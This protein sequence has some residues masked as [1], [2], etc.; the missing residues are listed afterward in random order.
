MPSP[1]SNTPSQ[2]AS[3][4]WSIVLTARQGC[5]DPT[6]RDAM[7]ELAR[8]YW[9]P[10]YAFVRR[11]GHNATEAED[12]IQ[13]FFTRLIEKDVLSQTDRSKGRFRSFLLAS[14]QNYLSNEQDKT[15]AQKRGGPGGILSLDNLSAETRYA[16][17]PADR[18]T[19]E[20][21]FEK[22]WALAVLEQVL[23]ALETEYHSR[24]QGETFTALKHLL[25]ETAQPCYGKV[26][27]TLHITE[28]AAK[29]AGHRLRS[30]YRDLLRQTIAD[31]VSDP[32]LIDEEI[33]HLLNS[34]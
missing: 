3:T 5:A 32:A 20:R 4:R 14:L 2:F 11:R 34:L 17:E 21:L 29:V 12:L 16:A 10:L 15:R 26:A 30:R 1:T 7:G 6:A 22:R 27:Q 33:Q 25:T 23:Q 28:N 8:T 9:F 18:L 24:G 19:P 13:G 31:T